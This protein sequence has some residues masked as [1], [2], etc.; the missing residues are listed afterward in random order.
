MDTGLPLM[1]SFDQVDSTPAGHLSI[2]SSGEGTHPNYL[3]CLYPPS[4]SSHPPPTKTWTLG[5]LIC[6]GQDHSHIR[7]I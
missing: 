6:D 3:I 4:L 1:R 2:V 5:N 7:H